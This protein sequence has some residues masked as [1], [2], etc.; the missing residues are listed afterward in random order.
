MIYVVH[1]KGGTDGNIPL[2]AP[3]SEK[4]NLRDKI[5]ELILQ[6][7]VTYDVAVKAL[8]WAKSTLYD[9]AEN[10]LNGTNVK[11]VFEKGKCE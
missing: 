9:Q 11:E 8:A 4:R 6:S 5:L 10:L 3:T 2:I 1:E 7:G